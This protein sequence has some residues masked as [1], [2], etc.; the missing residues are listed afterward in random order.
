MEGNRNRVDGSRRSCAGARRN[1]PTTSPT[2]WSTVDDLTFGRWDRESTA[3][4]RGLLARGVRPGDRVLLPCSTSDWTRYA[5]AWAARAQGRRRRRADLPVRRPR[6]G[7]ARSGR[8]PARSAWSAATSPRCRTPGTC[9]SADLVAAGSPEPLPGRPG[10]PATTPRSSTPPA[11]PAYPRAWWPRT[12]TCCTRC[13]PRARADPHRPARAAAR[14]HGRA[15][16][17]GA[18]A[19]GP[20]APHRHAG[21]V[22][23]R[24]HA[25]RDRAAP[26]H[27]RRA[28]AGD[29]HR[30]GQRV[31]GRRARP[32]LRTAGAHHQRADPPGHPG[33]ARGAVPGGQD[34][35]RLLDHRVLAA[36]AGHRL[37]PGPADLPRPPGRRRAGA[38]RRRGRRRAAGRHAGGRAAAQRRT[39]APVRRRDRPVGGVPPGRL[40]PHRRRRLGRP[41]RL[42]L[43]RRPQPGPGQ[44]RR[45]QRLHA[46]RRGDDDGVPRAWSRRRSAGCRTRC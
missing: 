44:H 37:R 42:L 6:R 7:R 21:P 2:A 8:P 36:P 17:A 11:R 10:S 40:D 19:V 15:G 34:P 18:A 3:A 32:Q 13:G 41:G 35:Q 46:R 43:P 31:R 39:A 12:R 33:G 4:A 26:A 16:P 45:A 38:D 30:A 14:H 24:R 20:A 5:V 23:R 1:G 29:G 27:R 22:H 9:R 25:R 28:R